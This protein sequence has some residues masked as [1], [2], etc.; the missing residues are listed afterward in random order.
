MRREIGWCLWCA[1]Y[2]QIGRRS[3]Q[4]ALKRLELARSEYRVVQ[5]AKTNGDVGA[6]CDQIL[7]RIGNRHFKP[8]Q[9]MRVEKFRQPRNDL[10]AFRRGTG[11]ARRMVPR[12]ESTPRAA[13]SAS[14]ISARISRARSRKSAPASV[15]VI[16]RVVRSRQRHTEAALS[17][18]PMIRDTD[19]L[20]QPEFAAGARK[21]SALRRA[22]ENP[23][24]C[25][26]SLILIQINDVH[27]YDIPVIGQMSQI[28]RANRRTETSHGPARTASTP[29]KPISKPAALPSSPPGR[30]WKPCIAPP[31]N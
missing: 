31:T 8:Q 22:H 28:V 9:R 18:S 26:R 7:P 17:S 16:L 4:H 14:S 2:F 27:D 29:S 21:T 15:T 11:K 13:S 30:R 12:S 1:A 3:H 23:Q 6:F 19:G 20:R 24:F 10:R 25:S 5:F